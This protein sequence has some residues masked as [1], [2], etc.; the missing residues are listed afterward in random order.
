VVLVN[1]E[2]FWTSHVNSNIYRDVVQYLFIIIE[3]T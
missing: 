1:V 3:F 2:I